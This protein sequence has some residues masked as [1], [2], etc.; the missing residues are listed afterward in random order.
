MNLLS[1]KREKEMSEAHCTDERGRTNKTVSWKRRRMRA[2]EGHFGFRG[3]VRSGSGR[4]DESG[5]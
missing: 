4:E 3:I 2:F 1:I 5:F